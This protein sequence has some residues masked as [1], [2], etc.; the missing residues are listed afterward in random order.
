MTTPRPLAGE[1]VL[2]GVQRRVVPHGGRAANCPFCG[3]TLFEDDWHVAATVVRDSQV[4]PRPATYYLCGDD[5]LWA[6]L[7]LYD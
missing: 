7:S 6:W 2:D 3:G 1:F 5:C 4:A